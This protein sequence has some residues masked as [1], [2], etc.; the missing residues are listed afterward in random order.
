MN[1]LSHLLFYTALSSGGSIC[2]LTVKILFSS[3]SLSDPTRPNCCEK[4]VKLIVIL[5]VIAIIIVIVNPTQL[6]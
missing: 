3:L 6:W 4:F 2:P 1:I 5:I